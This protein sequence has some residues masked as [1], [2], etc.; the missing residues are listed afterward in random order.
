MHALY[1]HVFTVL[2]SVLYYMIYSFV[3]FQTIIMEIYERKNK[4]MKMKKRKDST[5]KLCSISKICS[6]GHLTLLTMTITAERRSNIFTCD[7]FYHNFLTP[8][9]LRFKSYFF[10]FATVHEIDLYHKNVMI[11]IIIFQPPPPS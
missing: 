8:P 5:M 6:Y 3:S 1:R 2:L 10:F 11:F 4:Q 9:P 7:N